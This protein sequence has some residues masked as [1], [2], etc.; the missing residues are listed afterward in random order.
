MVMSILSNPSRYPNSKSLATLLVMGVAFS[1][2]ASSSRSIHSQR[3]HSCWQKLMWK[4]EGSMRQMMYMSDFPKAPGC[5]CCCLMLRMDLNCDL[6]P[7]SSKTSRTAVS[8][9][10]KSSPYNTS[11]SNLALFL[12]RWKACLLLSMFSVLLHKVFR[13]SVCFSNTGKS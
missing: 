12:E 13:M 7:V 9:G 4:E 11:E 10:G 5:S 8:P 3:R 6:M 1:V 2:R